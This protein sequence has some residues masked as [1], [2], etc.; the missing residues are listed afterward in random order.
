MP[1]VATIIGFL[2]VVVIVAAKFVAKVV[3]YWHE[4][5]SVG[6]GTRVWHD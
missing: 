2:A 5:S 6:E 4:A 1:I 3:F